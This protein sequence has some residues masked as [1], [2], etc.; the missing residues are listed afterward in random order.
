[1]RKEDKLT[2]IEA[3]TKQLGSNANFYL[4]DISD[5]NA[6][7][8]ARLRQLCF[9]RDIKLLVVKNTLLHKAM[10]RSS[11][12]MSELYVALK[13]ATA[14][15]F[16]ETGNAPAKLIKEFRKT[17]NRPILKGAFIEEAAYLGDDQID[18]LV[19]VKSKFDL[20]GELIGLLQSPAKNV[21]GALQ[22]GGQKLSGIVKTLS[23][24]SE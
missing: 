21:V 5:L 1:M 22:S 20:L 15:M 24:R 10:E 3:I 6:K 7:N 23:E 12:D 9:T 4:T 13:G 11:V 18:F 19:N 8:T 2:I 17:S 14:I 16:S